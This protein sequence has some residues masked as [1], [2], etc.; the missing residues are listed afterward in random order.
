MSLPAHPESPHNLG[1]NGGHILRKWYSRHR[2][3]GRGIPDEASSYICFATRSAPAPGRTPIPW[4]RE[5]AVHRGRDTGCHYLRRTG[6]SVKLVF[7]LVRQQPPKES[8]PQQE[9]L[10]QATLGRLFRLNRHATTTETRLWQNLFRV[11]AV[12]AP[13]D[14]KLVLPGTH[15]ALP[16]WARRCYCSGG[17][18][19]AVGKLS[20]LN[21]D[22]D[23]SND[24]QAPCTLKLQK[25]FYW[26]NPTYIVGPEGLSVQDVL[27]PIEP[28]RMLND[29]IINRGLQFCRS[30]LSLWC[31]SMHNEFFFFKTFFYTK[32]CASGTRGDL[33]T[34]LEWCIRR[35][36]VHQKLQLLVQFVVQWITV[37][38]QNNLVDCG[39]YFLHFVQRIL[40]NPMEF[41]S[42]FMNR[43]TTCAW[44]EDRIPGTR[45]KLIRC[46]SK[47]VN[48][49]SKLTDR[50]KS[51]R[52]TR[53]RR[54][55][56]SQSI[57][58]KS[59]LP[60]TRST[61]NAATSASLSILMH[62][63]LL[64]C[65]P[66]R[67]SPVQNI[68]AGPYICFP[69]RSIME[70]HAWQVAAMVPAL[71]GVTIEDLEARLEDG[72]DWNL[73]DETNVPECWGRHASKTSDRCNVS[74][75]YI[76]HLK[77]T[78]LGLGSDEEY[79]KH[80]QYLAEIET[81][82]IIVGDVEVPTVTRPVQDAVDA[83]LVQHMQALWLLQGVH[84][85]LV[86]NEFLHQ[87]P[88]AQQRL[89]GVCAGLDGTIST[90]VTLCDQQRKEGLAQ[91][92]PHDL[93][94]LRSVLRW[95]KRP[96]YDVLADMLARW[97]QTHADT[98]IKGVAVSKPKLIVDLRDVR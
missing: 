31:P 67:G 11:R 9:L 47:L 39:L 70:H 66:Q 59:I 65:L 8:L 89:K 26:R 16:R 36:A 44:D 38:Q 3:R 19:D 63:E 96:G 81:P 97:I 84:G 72:N 71:D 69:C 76:R 42:A 73:D 37:P 86:I 18:P 61:T 45:A 7:G 74:E 75:R 68:E 2:M 46:V 54:Q 92:S 85:C 53:W 56:R 98:T 22:V 79:T 27:R 52:G 6:A 21:M 60:D 41:I 40:D 78:E 62:V 13:F 94:K 90:K 5:R 55:R 33:T 77:A 24:D 51:M 64:R 80:E 50:D 10:L 43:D 23:K 29:K 28:G 12:K 57:R 17:S 14:L 25:G 15:S 32:L 87:D 83:V 58:W 88:A 20:H 48:N 35:V 1:P 91:L 49:F 82:R 4:R 93:E 34:R 30:D 95:M